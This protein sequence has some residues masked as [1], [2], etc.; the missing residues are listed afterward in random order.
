MMSVCLSVCLSVS[1]SVSVC[2]SVSVCCRSQT[3]QREYEYYHGKQGGG[4]GGARGGGRRERRPRSEGEALSEEAFTNGQFGSG[5]SVHRM[6]KSPSQ[7]ISSRLP[8]LF[9]VSFP[10]SFLGKPHS[11]NSHSQSVIS[12]IP[13]LI[14]GK[15]SCL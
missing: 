6:L 12:L 1:V 11:C 13:N 7:P 9:S 8:H 10:V 14:S 3:K 4:G 2:L 5:E 15:T